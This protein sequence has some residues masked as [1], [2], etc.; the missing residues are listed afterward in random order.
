MTA[1]SSID[2][3]IKDWSWLSGNARL[4]DL[5]GQLLGA[6][7]AHAGLIMF[8]AGSITLLEVTRFLP[9]EP[10]YDQGLLLIPNLARLGWGIGADGAVVDTYPY[11]VIGMLHLVASAVLGAGGLF[12]V[13]RGAAVLKDGE[14]RAPKFHYEWDDPQKLGFILGHHLIFLG[15]AALLFVAKAMFWGGIYDPALAEVRVIANPTIS[16]FTIFGYVFGLVDGQP[17]PLGMAAVD[18]LEDVIGGH[19]WIGLL[20]IAGGAWHI[21]TEPLSWAKKGFYL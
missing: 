20:C 12:H 8:W 1:T 16:P 7:I 6:H 13:F 5:S 10:M 9:G 2:T 4:I 21:T 17:N 11:F 14:G 3:Q 18:N 15:V 19:I